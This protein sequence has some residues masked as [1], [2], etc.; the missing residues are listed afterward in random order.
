MF[1]ISKSI[2]FSFLKKIEEKKLIISN[3]TEE[4]G[5]TEEVGETPDPEQIDFNKGKLI[6]NKEKNYLRK[7]ETN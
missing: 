4:K 6:I 2:E 1:Q 5:E 7:K 3:E